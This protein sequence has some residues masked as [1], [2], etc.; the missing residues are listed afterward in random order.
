MELKLEPDFEGM[1]RGRCAYP[2]PQE[3]VEEME[4][5][6]QECIDAS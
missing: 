1:Q 5:Q 4:R 2:A 3:Q 6:I